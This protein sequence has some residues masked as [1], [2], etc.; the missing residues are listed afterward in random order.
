MIGRG[1]VALRRKGYEFVGNFSF[2]CN[3][4][5]C[6][7]LL[8]F[9]VVVVVFKGGSLVLRNFTLLWR[10]GLITTD[11]SPGLGFETEFQITTQYMM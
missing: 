5:V 10:E 9:V 3:L 11:M 1:V 6:C 7:L 4:F 8:L 2:L